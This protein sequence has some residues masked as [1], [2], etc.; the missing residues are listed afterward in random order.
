MTGTFDF[1]VLGGGIAGTSTAAHLAQAGSVCLLEMEDQP[2]YHAT[3]RSA[4][5]FSEAYGND[6]IRCLTRASRKHFYDPPQGFC[7]SAL[8]RPRGVL[9]LAHDGQADV[10]DA[11]IESMSVVE[12]LER[13][14]AQ[15]AAA[16]CPIV[17]PECLVG[18]ALGR[19]PA[20]ID[21]HELH[22]GYL[23]KLRAQ[24]G[25]ARMRTRVSGLVHDGSRWRVETSEGEVCADVVINA[26]GAWANELGTLAGA[27]DIGLRALKRTAC[28]VPA[29]PGMNVG[30]WPMV[31]NVAEEFYLKPDA[32]LLL[33]SPADE[34]PS[35]PCDAQADEL[36]V[37]IAI[38]RVQQATTL[39][40]R[41]V[42]HRWAG[43]RSFVADSS[44]V[45]GFDPLAPHFFW[46]A[47]LGGFGIQTAPAVGR[48]AAQLAS[49]R[50][51]DADIL[52]HGVD[53]EA[54]RPERSY[55]VDGM[56]HRIGV[57]RGQLG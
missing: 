52:E 24:G 51:M 3:G 42:S 10:L 28:L 14:S 32:G 54:L 13:L 16:L 38:D 47:A 22:Q 17:R 46:V 31:V 15:E 9:A 56:E 2:G 6:V 20:D 48:I 1:V 30:A 7:A 43:L 4:A 26:A 45:V 33:L 36:D 19:G 21:V 50:G 5:L 41:R 12:P 53:V 35:P 49:R 23:R 29:P 27:L 37:A 11:F 40:V 44:P 39:D 55:S 57:A 18:A 8:V 34:T 25:Q